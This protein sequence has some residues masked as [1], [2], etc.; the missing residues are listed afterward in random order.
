MSDVCN[1]RVVLVGHGY[2]GKNIARNLDAL[3]VLYG[4]C[5]VSREA[6][7]RAA[8]AYPSVRLFSTYDDV[9]ADPAVDAVALSTSA[10]LHA[11][12]AIQAMHGGKDVFVE[13]PLALTY[14]DGTRVVDAANATGRVLMIGHLLEYHPAI[15][16]LEEMVRHGELGRLE[17]VYSNRLNL[18]KFRREE[19]ILWSFAPH[20]I[21]VILRLAGDRPIELS[22]TGGTYLQANVA[23]ITVTHM[24]FESGLRAHVFVSW[25]HPYKEQKLVV[26]GSKK[27]AVFDDR[28]PTG[29]KLILHDKGADWDGNRPI[30]RSGEGVSIP[31]AA[32]E[33]LRLEMQHFLSCLK[34]R[35]HPRTDGRSALDVLQVL[36]TAQRSSDDGRE[37]FAHPGGR[38]RAG[39]QR[40]RRASISASAVGISKP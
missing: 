21:A 16:K 36:Q 17:Y 32:D 34:S 18:G 23:D 9:L 39:H 6:L 28:A 10:Y 27:M 33:P 38:N 8:G 24:L 37:A 12:Q 15:L 31:I 26:V 25:L 20:D 3:G 11:E 19:N 4:V 5:D 14:R 29:E 1:S 35:E 40:T 7:V 30:A 13:K 22:A 2:W